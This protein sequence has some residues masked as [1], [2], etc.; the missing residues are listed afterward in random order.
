MAAS[1]FD[2]TD[3]HKRDALNLAAT[4]SGR[5]AH[6]L[7]KDIWVVWCLNKLFESE[8]GNH[9]VFKG[10]TSLSKAYSVIN[11]FSEDI[12]VTLDIRQMI[13][14][15]TAKGH[16]PSNQ[17]QRKKWTD[18]IKREL[19][20]W[21]EQSILP[22]LTDKVGQGQLEATVTHENESL[23]IEYAAVEKGSGYVR[24][25]VMLEF[26]AR[27]TGEPASYIE[28]DCDAARY[29]D[30][31]DFPHAKPRVMSAERTFWEKATA[32]HVFVAADNFS[33]DRR[34]RHWYDLVCLYDHGIAQQAINDRIL[35]NDVA[36]HKALFFRYRDA[37][38]QFV[39]YSEAVN[40]HLQLRPT[41]ASLEQ[42]ANDYARMVGDGLLFEDSAPSFEH[43]MTKCRQIE[44]LANSAT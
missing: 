5:P 7:E 23:F 27:S 3:E 19:P 32:C 31:V 13:P 11:R 35:A 6:L 43:M 25:A 42:L 9:L 37:D 29:V 24:P 26:G 14:A 20:L 2:L 40:G 28:V 1:F 21:L 15:L 16:L 39:N 41:K 30:G 34:A 36:T 8:Y 12:D 44:E 22:L 18:A 38:G 17:S 4:Q 33:I 10:G